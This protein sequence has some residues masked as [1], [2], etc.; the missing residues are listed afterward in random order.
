MSKRP[1]LQLLQLDS[2]ALNF[3]YNLTKVLDFLY[4]GSEEIPGQTQLLRSQNITHIVNASCHAYYEQ[5][6]QGLYVRLDLKDEVDEQ[7]RPKLDM[8]FSLIESARKQ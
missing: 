5:P 8:A 2:Q 3:Q 7:I 4:I 6:E 1:S